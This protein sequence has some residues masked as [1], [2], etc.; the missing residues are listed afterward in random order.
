MGKA[1]SIQTSLKGTRSMIFTFTKPQ[2]GIKS[3]AQGK[4]RMPPLRIGLLIFSKQYHV[5]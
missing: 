5:C 3:L 4:T 1:M 2:N